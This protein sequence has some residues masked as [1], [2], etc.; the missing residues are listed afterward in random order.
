MLSIIVPLYNVEKYIEKCL[1]SIRVQE[2]IDFEVLLIDDGSVDNSA[3]ICKKF[4]ESDSRFR[5]FFQENGGVSRARNKGIELSKGQII[6]FVDSDDWLHPGMF[7]RMINYMKETVADAVICDATTVWDDGNTQL[8]TFSALDKSCTLKRDEVLPDILKEF[9]GAVWRCIYKREVIV[10][11]ATFPVGQKLSEDKIFNIYALG[12]CNK[13]AYL[14]ESLYYRY[15][16]DGSA[17]NQYYANKFEI[18]LRAYQE[19]EKGIREKWDISYMP[20]YQTQFVWNCVD[21]INCVCSIRYRTS[22]RKMYSDIK[23]ICDNKE[24]CMA[25][26]NVKSQNY[27]ID[28]IR[29]KRYIQVLIHTI[30]ANIRHRR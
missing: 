8:D 1:E 26:R 4:C 15:M 20:S 2:Y 30:L 23:L 10:G 12:S 14:K 24:V 28:C 13:I 21:A 27:R 16:R 17:V 6:G 18:V 3:S 22:L 5:Y 29:K 7:K 25:I 11:N 9:T 19:I